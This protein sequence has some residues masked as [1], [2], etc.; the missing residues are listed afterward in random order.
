MRYSSTFVLVTAFCAI[1]AWTLPAS[2]P[3][4]RLDTRTTMYYAADFT[5]EVDPE[6]TDKLETRTTMYYAA[7]FTEDVDP[8]TV[9]GDE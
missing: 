6:T 8:E 3:D 1:S 5:E 7:D 9:P 4:D 2:L